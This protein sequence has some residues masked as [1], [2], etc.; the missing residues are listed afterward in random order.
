MG[1]SIL[2]MDADDGDLW[3]WFWVTVLLRL[4]SQP[5]TKGNGGF[6]DGFCLRGGI[7]M[8]ECFGGSFS[9]GGFGGSTDFV[10]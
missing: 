4:G 10:R 7:G 2:K 8:D 3:V 9:G 1:Y 6:Y 5:R